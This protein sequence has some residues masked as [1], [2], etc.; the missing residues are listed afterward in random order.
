M[1]DSRRRGGAYLDHMLWTAE[2]LASISTIPPVVISSEPTAADI[3]RAHQLIRENGWFH[4]LSP[5]NG[6]PQ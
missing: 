3:A 1:D 4:L 5:R 6:K 2:L